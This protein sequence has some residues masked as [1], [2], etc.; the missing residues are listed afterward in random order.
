MV[1]VSKI[2]SCFIMYE[3]MNK[4][5]PAFN[6]FGVFDIK[7]KNS[8]GFIYIKENGL[9][10]FSRNFK[11][12]PPV[13]VLFANMVFLKTGG[14]CKVRK[15]DEYGILIDDCPDFIVRDVLKEINF[16]FGFLFIPLETQCSLYARSTAKTK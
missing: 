12:L 10:I 6:S 14:K 1:A 11:K 13:F 7:D 3:Y 4:N 8:L 5:M 9:E 15:Y 2:I 16:Q